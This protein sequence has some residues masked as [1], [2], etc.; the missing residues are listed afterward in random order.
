[1]HFNEINTASHGHKGLYFKYMV[2]LRQQEL[3]KT[4]PNLHY[5]GQKKFVTIETTCMYIDR[6][7]KSKMA[8]QLDTGIAAN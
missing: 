3:F 4:D 1:M 7:P 2:I 8:A 6:S 5:N